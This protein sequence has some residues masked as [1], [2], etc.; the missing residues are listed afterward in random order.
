MGPFASGLK[1]RIAG[2]LTA[3]IVIALNLWITEQAIADWAHGAG[4]YAPLI[5]TGCL[6]IAGALCGLLVWIAVHPYRRR[7]V[8]ATLGLEERSADLITAPTYRRIL[9]P[10]DHSP[11]DRIALSHAAGLAARTNGRIYLRGFKVLKA[12]V[13]NTGPWKDISDHAAFFAEAKYDWPPR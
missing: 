5:W 7:A 12:Q 4:N 11:L 2:W 10:L 8:T 9:V 1:L 3:L 13:L 6:S